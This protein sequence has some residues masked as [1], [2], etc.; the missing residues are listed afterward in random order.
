[1]Y[2]FLVYYSLLLSAFKVMVQM[3]Y[4]DRVLAYEKQGRV[5]P[6][7]LERKEMGSVARMKKWF[8]IYSLS[9]LDRKQWRHTLNFGL[10][11]QEESVN[12]HLRW[13]NTNST[14]RTTT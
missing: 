7:A 8:S 13:C 2:M 14:L 1:M 3:G 11:S 6:T 5:L 4:S 9:S 10:E 12:T